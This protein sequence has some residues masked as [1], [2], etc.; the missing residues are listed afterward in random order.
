MNALHWLQRKLNKL[1]T[2]VPP[3]PRDGDGQPRRILL[4]HCHPL[5]DSY[6]DSLAAAVEE[7]ARQ[8]GHEI[9]RR[10][11]YQ[12]GFQPALTAAERAHY[13]DAATGVGR[14][15]ARPDLARDVVKSLADLRWCDSLVL[16]YPTWWL[17]MPAMLKGWFDRTLIPGP[18]GVGAWDFPPPDQKGALINGLLPRLMNIERMVCVSTYGAPKHLVML[19]GDNGRNCI[20]TAIRPV[21]SPEC[22]CKWMGLYQLDGLSQSE[23]ARFRSTVVSAIRDL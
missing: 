13:L 19:G 1:T 15:S 10:S 14:E 7:G 5:S 9:R 2:Y 11:L 6:S 12:E 23:R 3:P 21:F 8:G 18:E 20:G 17:N 4:V 22:T 16:V